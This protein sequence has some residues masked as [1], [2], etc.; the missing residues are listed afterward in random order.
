MRIYLIYEAGGS[1]D[2][3]QVMVVLVAIFTLGIAGCSQDAQNSD[4]STATANQSDEE[5]ISI[6]DFS[7][8]TITFNSVPQNI[9]ALG[10]GEMDIIYALGGEL[11]GRATTGGS[12]SV[13]VKEAEDVMEVGSAHGM[14][15]EKVTSLQPDVVL[16]N[17]PMNLNDIPSVEGIGSQMVL[18]SA[19]SIDEIKEQITLFGDLLKEEEKSK[20]IVQTIDEKINTIQ[21]QQQKEKPRILLVYGAPGTNMAALPNSLSG[22]ILELA[23][24]ENIA[25]DYPGLESYPQYAQL[26]A[27]RIIEANP[28]IILFMGHGNPDQVKDSFITEMEQNAGWQHLDA[29]KNNRFEILPSNLFGSNPG[30]QIVDSL[31]YLNN[32]LTELES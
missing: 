21:S 13:K 16:G 26:N 14:D 29:V 15:L 31:D 5:T 1:L 2:M 20:E 3:K 30:T 8:R 18:T 4:N 19:N 25:K 7:D 27:E 17:H 23:G 10:D 32:L 24:G 9:V 12:A 22:D 6:T 11:V 28:Q